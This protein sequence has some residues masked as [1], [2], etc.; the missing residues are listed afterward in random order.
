MKRFKHFKGL[1]KNQIRVFE[2]I[3]INHDQG[4]NPITLRSL[5]K[6]GLIR[7]FRDPLSDGHSLQVIV[8]RY[9]VPIPIHTDWCKW[10]AEKQGVKV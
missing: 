5:E 8:K 10:C 1:T 9:Y 6:R 3:A 7:S 2:E 4:H